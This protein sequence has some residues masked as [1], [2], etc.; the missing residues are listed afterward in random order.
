VSAEKDGIVDCVE[1]A[2]VRL[3][4]DGKA[5][6]MARTDTYGDFKFDRLKE[7]SGAYVV[8]IAAGGRPTRT[9]EAT[10]GASVYLGEIR[11]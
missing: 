8:E 2:A 11:V 10:L 1:G 6:G 3:L 7:N 4:K 5:V 9:L